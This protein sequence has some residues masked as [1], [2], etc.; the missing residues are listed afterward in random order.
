[1]ISLIYDYVNIPLSR[2]CLY[3]LSNTIHRIQNVNVYTNVNFRMLR[4]NYPLG[5]FIMYVCSKFSIKVPYCID[6]IQKPCINR[7]RYFKV[8]TVQ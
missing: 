6:T 1:M 8:F 5:N 2:F 4:Y 7:V 3:K